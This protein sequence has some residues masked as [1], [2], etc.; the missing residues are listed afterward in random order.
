MG[1]DDF[2]MSIG[3][4]AGRMGVSVSRVRQ[5]DEQLQPKRHT[6]GTRRYS[7]KRV[8]EIL[9]MRVRHG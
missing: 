4:V 9:A 2:V 7:L 3:D 5:L 1:D 6:N 8:A